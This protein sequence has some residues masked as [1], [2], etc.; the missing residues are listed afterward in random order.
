MAGNIFGKGSPGGKGWKRCLILL[1]AV[2]VGA[3]VFVF[4]GFGFNR[5]GAAGKAAAGGGM[6]LG[7]AGDCMKVSVQIREFW[8]DV[9]EKTAARI[10]QAVREGNFSDAERK[11]EYL[12]SLESLESQ[13]AKLSYERFLQNRCEEMLDRTYF[14]SFQVQPPADFDGNTRE[15]EFAA[16]F[17]DLWMNGREKI[18][19]PVSE[20]GCSRQE[21]ENSTAGR[22]VGGAVLARNYLPDY[23]SLNG[24]QSYEYQYVEGSDRVEN[25]TFYNNS[26]TGLSIQEVQEHLDQLDEFCVQTLRS[27]IGRWGLREDMTRRQKAWLVYQWVGYYLEFDQ[28]QQIH[29]VAAAI[30]SREGVCE[31]YMAIY[32]RMCTLLGIPT[33]GQYGWL[34]GDTEHIWAVQLD[35]AGNVF[36]TDPTGGDQVGE[37]WDPQEDSTQELLDRFAGEW[38]GR[39]AEP[40][41]E[42]VFFWQEKI[43]DTHKAYYEYPFPELP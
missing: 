14:D 38:F 35:E 6:G 1:L 19:I 9:V 37:K 40:S 33:Y 23:A 29:D 4:G 21:F 3:V 16:L 8:K 27:L 41:R 7:K 12:E 22:I 32:F 10:D 43:W 17:L 11:I 28:S 39:D 42:D 15:N 34:N 36:Y 26:D 13:S 24:K 20:R 25:I 31:T 2:G 18:S 5:S 30:E